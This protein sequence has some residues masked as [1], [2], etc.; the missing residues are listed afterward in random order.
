ME[1]GNFCWEPALAE[2][3]TIRRLGAKA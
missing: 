3:V 1:T 2:Q